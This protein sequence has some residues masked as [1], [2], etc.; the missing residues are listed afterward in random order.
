M[1]IVQCPHCA[2]QVT[3]DASL[4][5]QVVSCPRCHGQFQMPALPQT[6]GANSSF[7]GI[8]EDSGYRPR[9]RREKGYT[10]VWVIAVVSLL[11]V[12]FT[13]LW[14]SGVVQINPPQ[15]PVQQAKNTGNAAATTNPQPDK[16]CQGTPEDKRQT[17]QPS[18][19]DERD[20]ELAEAARKK[21]ADLALRQN[22]IDLALAGLDEQAKKD[23]AEIDLRLASYRRAE[24]N[25]EQKSAALQQNSRFGD[26]F[27]PVINAQ[28]KSLNDESQAL[29]ADLRAISRLIETKQQAFNKKR[30][31]ILQQF[32]D[33]KPPGW[34]DYYGESR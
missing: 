34:A 32:P 31:D 16:G 5:G 29:Q 21:A 25:W 19:Q 20:K 11:G 9:R 14:I 24:A 13:A 15:K 33:T 3:N 30:D 8:E 7:E 23:I 1:Q 12:A 28:M 2:T 6:V 27:N 4:K 17:I 26:P 10:G 18:G 22:Q